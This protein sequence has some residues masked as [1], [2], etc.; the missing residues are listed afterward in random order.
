MGAIALGRLFV[1]QHQRR[2]HVI[3]QA[4]GLHHGFAGQPT[5]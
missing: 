5:A 1:L 3:H 4:L 2:Q